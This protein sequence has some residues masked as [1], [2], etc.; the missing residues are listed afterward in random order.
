VASSASTATILSGANDK[1]MKDNELRELFGN[2]EKAILAATATIVGG[3][4]KQV[5]D[6]L[7]KRLDAIDR[8]LKERVPPP[9]AL[10]SPAVPVAVGMAT[11]AAIFL[12]GMLSVWIFR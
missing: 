2:L 10:P 4:T 7:R 9:F 12:A 1:A 3:D 11:G 8:A 5:D 6:A